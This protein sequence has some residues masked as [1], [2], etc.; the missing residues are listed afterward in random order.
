[1][2]RRLETFAGIRRIRRRAPRRDHQQHAG[3]HQQGAKQAHPVHRLGRLQDAEL[4]EQQRSRHLPE[5][6]ADYRHRARAYWEER[7][8]ALGPEVGAYIREVFDS[9]DVLDQLRTVQA[10]VSHLVDFPPARA[11]AACLRAS[12]YGSYKYGALKAIL[13]KGLDFEPLPNVVAIATPPLAAPRFARNVREMLQY[14]KE[15]WHE[16][17]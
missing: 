1:M 11:K 8:D 7:A 9:D 3:Q 10:I 15:D 2:P 12:F 14:T 16:P 5:H 13:R 17:H 4:V 6:R